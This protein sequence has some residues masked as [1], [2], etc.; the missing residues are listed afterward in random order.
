MPIGTLFSGIRSLKDSFSAVGSTNAIQLFE[1]AVTCARVPLISTLLNDERSPTS[2]VNLH[3][4]IDAA[5]MRSELHSELDHTPHL[6]SELHVALGKSL[7]GR[8][9][10]DRSTDVQSR[11]ERKIGAGKP[12]ARL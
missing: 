5:L 4:S 11:S 8:V 12:E 3:Q 1:T 6:K 7:Q 10:A 2:R 9:I